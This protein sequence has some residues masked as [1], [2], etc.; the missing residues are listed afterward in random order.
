TQFGLDKNGYRLSDTQAQQILD[1]RLQRLTALEQDKIVAEYK[2]TM[3]KIADLIDVLA[4]PARVTQIISR[5]LAEVKE[6]YGDER[7]TEI[8]TATQEL[9]TEDLIA[10]EDVVV[11]L[12]HGGYMKSQPVTDYRAQRRGGRG[13]QATTTKDD[14][15]VEK[16]F[17]ANTHDQI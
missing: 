5:E 14:D 4:K 7:K 13:R 8:V 6:R 16:L 3:E 17:I 9:S 1:L 10:A 15:F 12:S 11:T 2:E